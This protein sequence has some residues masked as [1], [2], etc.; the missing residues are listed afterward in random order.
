M[1]TFTDS[2][3]L[4]DSLK[5]TIFS[6]ALCLFIAIGSARLILQEVI[7]LIV[8]YKRLKLVLRSEVPPEGL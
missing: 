4:F 6:I 5:T 8:I 3:V 7:A 2:F 1:A